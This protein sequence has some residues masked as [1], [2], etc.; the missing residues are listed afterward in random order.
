[1]PPAEEAPPAL[2]NPQKQQQIDRGEHGNNR[3]Q[4]PLLP[5]NFVYE[6]VQLSL[7]LLPLHSRISH[8]VV[9]T[10]QLM[11]LGGQLRH[12]RGRR[13]LRLVVGPH[14][15]LNRGS[16]LISVRP[17]RR[18]LVPTTADAGGILVRL[19]LVAIAE[20]SRPPL[21]LMSRPASA[22]P[23]RTGTKLIRHWSNY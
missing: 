6:F 12:D 16:L 2:G 8:I 22:P 5:S 18:G 13:P 1:M 14:G 3:L 11:P 20:F 19:S 10:L 21:L 23:R 7:G 17:L 15:I 4:S 9:R